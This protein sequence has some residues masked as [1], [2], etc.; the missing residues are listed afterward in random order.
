MP[1]WTVLLI[2]D[3]P[4]GEE[5]NIVLRPRQSVRI[6][7]GAVLP[8]G[9]DAIVPV[10]HTSLGHFEPGSTIPTQVSI[11]HPV[12]AGDNIRPRCQ[13]F[14]M[15]DILLEPNKCIRPQ[16]VGVIAMQGYTE[17]EVYRRPKIGIISSGDELLAVGL[18]WKPGKIFDSN[19]YTL[20]AQTIKSNCD[21]VH[22][23]TIKD[24]YADV[25]NAL[26]FAVVERVDLLLT[27]AGVSMGAFD[28]VRAVVEQHGNL[29]FWRVNMRPGKPLAFGNY[30]NTTFVGLP[31]NPVSAF[32]GFEV[33][34]RPMLQKMSGL[35]NYE[36]TPIKVRLLQSLE[37]DGRE[38]YLR[39]SII[40]E[41]G[42]WKGRL[43][44]HQGSGNLLSLVQANALIIIPSG[45]HF[46]P[47]MSELDAWLID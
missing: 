13:D 44:G 6:V 21:Y 35:A 16:D 7:T 38:S 22:L 43:S 29:V 30:K 47:A 36:R 33:F 20:A 23:G 41:S 14:K 25:L 19:S 45:Q 12:Q 42:E 24:S 2:G 9:A 40:R 1:A 28:Y 3:I 8:Q 15:G 46:V 26:D 4:A 27:S 32:I 39:A 17:V 34:V 5:S 10:E 18:P 31:G 11:L 37:S